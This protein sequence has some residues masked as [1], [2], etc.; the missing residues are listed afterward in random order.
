MKML[1]HSDSPYIRG[2]GFL[3]LRFR[4]IFEILKIFRVGSPPRKIH[5]TITFF[6]KKNYIFSLPP[7][8]LLPFFEDYLED[9]DEIDP[10]AGGGDPMTIGQMVNPRK[11][12]T[13]S[14]I[15]MI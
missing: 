15:E 11:G 4:W 12:Q 10:K 3:Y 7:E 8:H 5:E 6:Q 2:L 14:I 13:V 1:N 9:E